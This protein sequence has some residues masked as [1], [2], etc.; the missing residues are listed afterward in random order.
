MATGNCA[1]AT[2]QQLGRAPTDRVKRLCC[3]HAVHV[4]YP[5]AGLA[6]AWARVEQT[7]GN[8]EAIESPLFKRL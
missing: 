8:S 2:T 7:H 3:Q 6:A 5:D 4:D 1:L